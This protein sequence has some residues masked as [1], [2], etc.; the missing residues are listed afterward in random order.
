MGYELFD[1]KVM[2]VSS[3]ALTIHTD[4]KIALNADVGDIF[5]PL[6]AKYVQILWDQEACKLAIRPLTKQD[7]HT[8]KLTFLP[9]KRG[10]SLSARR[11]LK[12]IQWQS[13]KAIAVPVQ[14][15]KKE[16]ML[17]AVLPRE[18]VGGKQK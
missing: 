6:G 12:Y 4:G 1:S 14:W 2:R 18:R 16:G 7:R 9:G 13:P 10:G 11:F 15:N 17:E 5:G 8:F 3:P